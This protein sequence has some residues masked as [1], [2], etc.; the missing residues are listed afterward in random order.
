M[1]AR[2]HR[3]GARSGRSS[4]EAAAREEALLR[5]AQRGDR[6]AFGQLVR[7]HRP[8][9]VA[10][11]LQLTGCRQDAE[12]VA[13]ETFLR[14]W[15]HLASFQGRSAFGTWLYRIA[16]RRALSLRSSATQRL[17]RAV[18]PDDP[19]LRAAVAVDAGSDPQRALQLRDQY[20]ALLGAFDALSGPLRA[21]VALT[22]LHGLSHAE[23]AEVLGVREGTVAWRVHEARRR[24]REALQREPSP[25]TDAGQRARTTGGDGLERLLRRLA[26]AASGWPAPAPRGP[27]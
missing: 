2:G 17:V 21:T 26:E 3:G 22:V 15:R 20:A 12:D 16:V 18:P 10:L 6:R 27:R 1:A 19:R 7:L 23:A 5:A 24:L 9:I 13:Q 25:A 4:G 8:R 11:G 14:A